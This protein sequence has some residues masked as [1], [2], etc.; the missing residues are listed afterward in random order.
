MNYYKIN[1]TVLT[2]VFI[3]SGEEIQKYEYI[4]DK[5]SDFIRIIN[6]KKLI[7]LLGK[8]YDRYLELIAN[9]HAYKNNQAASLY[10]FLVNLRLYHYAIDS[11]TEYKINKGIELGSFCRI[12]TF[13]KDHNNQPY[14]PG[15]SI[16]GMLINSISSG[17]FQDN[18]KIDIQ[19]ISSAIS[20]SDSKP[21]S[22]D[23]LMLNKVYRYNFKKR[24]ES[25]LNEYIEILKPG[26][27]IN[28]VLSLDE[29]IIKIDEIKD[30]LKT[31]Y[32]AYDKYYLSKFGG[33]DI[34]FAKSKNNGI[35][36][37]L[38][39]YTGYPTKTIIYPVYK[40]KAS[41]IAES[42]L[43]KKSKDKEKEKDNDKAKNDVFPLCLKC[44]QING[45]L[46]EN[47]A[48]EIAFE[49]IDLKV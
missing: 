6:Q 33:K 28:S 21:I 32:S 19:K 40:E 16:K 39:A 9:L 24:K 13:V 11:L 36:S 31:T 44:T 2:S 29:K 15:S 4:D 8:N 22:T 25:N 18:K 43:S 1:I 46:Q 38:G 26:T 30:H 41:Q 48:I 49:K 35:I 42:L 34:I 12:K 45:K 47:G 27:Q 37:Y 23:D 17:I 5:K 3:G 7:E 14:V 10:D 20:V